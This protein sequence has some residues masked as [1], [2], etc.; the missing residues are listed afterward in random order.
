M[1]SFTIAWTFLLI[2]C[3]LLGAAILTRVGGDCL[4]QVGDRLMIST[5][6]GLI[7]LS[8]ILFTISLFFPLS[9]TVGTIV[10]ICCLSI[11]CSS[12]KIRTSI[13]NFQLLLSPAKIIGFST[14]NIIV[15]TY[16]SQK[17]IWFDTGLYHFQ[18]IQWLSRFGV[19]P[20]LALIH[21][22]FG[23]VSSWFA[24][25]APLNVGIFQARWTAFGNGFILFLACLQ[26]SISLFRIWINN[27]Q[28]ADWFIIL[29]LGLC[30]PLL[31]WQKL[32]ISASPD[33]PVIL[34]T[35][36]ISWTILIIADKHQFCNPENS[37]LDLTII[38][39][40][41]SVGAFTIKPS[42]LPLLV[43]SFSF[44]I[45]ACQ[46][47][48]RRFVWGSAISLM[49]L[50]PLLIFSILT[51]G[52]PLY[53]VP[54]LCLNLPWSVGAEN[55]KVMSKIIQNWA[56][57]SGPTPTN[58]N[59]WNW[60]ADWL[61]YNTNQFTLVLVIISLISSIKVFK[62]LR[63]GKNNEYKYILSLGIF[64]MVFMLLQAPTFRFGLGYLTIIPA[65]L[66]AL[67]YQKFSSIVALFF[68]GITGL[69]ALVVGWYKTF[70]IILL[71]IVLVSL[72]IQFYQRTRGFKLAIIIVVLGLTLI[73]N[74]AIQAGGYTQI[75]LWLPPE[76]KAPSRSEVK[77]ANN[78]DYIKPKNSNQCWAAELIC[79]PN[80]LQNVQFRDASKGIKSGFKKLE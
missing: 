56:R 78:I 8:L 46:W 18:A 16:I 79:T 30:F 60:I 5:W 66:G 76:M 7:S 77:S 35:I 52:C 48:W 70:L 51:S 42:A 2:V 10:I 57:W 41:L 37:S 50:L 29:S 40:L 19:V 61:N 17:I 75:Y 23:F 47:Q 45:L 15:A 3:Y 28:K 11:A 62:Q 27:A 21:N 49:T 71:I 65:Y 67:Y 4:E 1:L 73:L 13:R 24:L 80:N 12:S 26:L 72:F 25:V 38:P 58:A 14:L 9:L 34:L 32:I 31:I 74:K 43:I 63:I 33:V 64:G 55:A 59:A 20:G 39:L 36:I 68:L 53:P 69:L 44:Y 54:I 6:L 22:R